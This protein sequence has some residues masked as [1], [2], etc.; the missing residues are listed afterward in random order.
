M[1]KKKKRTKVDKFN[2]MSQEELLAEQK[3]LFENARTYQYNDESSNQMQLFQQYSS[4][5]IQS[6]NNLMNNF[7]DVKSYNSYGFNNQMSG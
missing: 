6:N 3:K 5:Q 7:Q 2:G 4:E 1:Q